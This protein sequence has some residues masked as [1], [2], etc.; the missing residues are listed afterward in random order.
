VIRSRGSRV[1]AVML[2]ALV[3]CSTSHAA[4]G[5]PLITQGSDDPNAPYGIVAINYHF[6]DAHP[7][8]PLAANRTVTWVNEATLKHNVTFPSIGFS[9][10]LPVGGTLTIKDLGE[11]LGG[12]GVYT[13]YCKYHEPLG[14][15]G[16]IVI[17]G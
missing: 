10:D 1:L 12:P 6:H 13:F 4:S 7:S 15:V 5:P 3:A 11:K 16:T 9:E 2:L 14:M 8:I 17:K